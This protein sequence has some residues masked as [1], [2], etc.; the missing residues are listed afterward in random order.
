MEERTNIP[1][2]DCASADVG[3]LSSDFPAPLALSVD[4]TATFFNKLENALFFFSSIFCFFAA[5]GLEG[6]SN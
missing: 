5:F 2:L 3:D 6:T 1:F 4:G